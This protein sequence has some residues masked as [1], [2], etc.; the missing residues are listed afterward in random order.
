MTQISFADFFNETKKRGAARPVVQT[1]PAVQSEQVPARLISI[2]TARK[3]FICL[4]NQTARH[5]HR[6]D[7]FSDFVRLAASELDIARVRTPENAENCRK[8][9]ARYDADDIRN[10]H[11]LFARW[12]LNSMTSSAQ[13]LWSL[14]WGREEWGN[15]LPPI[16]SSQ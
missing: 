10:F 8:I 9:C 2:D 13:F 3:L 5:L 4:F 1:A 14:S 12:R 16:L 7:V 6:W 11:E 15:I